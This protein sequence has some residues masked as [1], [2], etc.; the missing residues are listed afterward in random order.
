M[1]YGTGFD[2]KLKAYINH[3][4]K[5]KYLCKQRIL[6]E[7]AHNELSH[8]AQHCLP[9]SSQFCNDALFCKN[10]STKI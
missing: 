9:F 1:L 6:D 8:M 7:A 4:L 3:L 10:G 5:T 2:K